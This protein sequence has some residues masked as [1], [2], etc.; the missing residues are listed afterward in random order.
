MV[1]VVMDLV[2]DIEGFLYGQD[3]ATSNGT[4]VGR[5]R[6]GVVDGVSGGDVVIGGGSRRGTAANIVVNDVTTMMMIPGAISSSAIN[7]PA[8]SPCPSGASGTR[9]SGIRQVYLCFTHSLTNIFDLCS[10][11][12]LTRALGG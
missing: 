9:R 7:V 6:S 4:G 3:G 10:Y 11:S 12:Y 5:G 1:A 8:I 2:N